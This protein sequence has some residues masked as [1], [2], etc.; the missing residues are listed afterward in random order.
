MAVSTVRASSGAVPYTVELSD[1]EGHRWIGDEPA[2]V[3]GANAGPSPE[4]LLLSALGSCTAATLLMY[5]RRKQWLLTQVHVELAFNPEGKPASGTD[6]S[7]SIQLVGQLDDEQRQ[8]LLQVAN[9]C[10]IHKV[11]T[12]EVRIATALATTAD[13]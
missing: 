8:R 13:A 12:G 7:R 5:A 6:I 10:P 3:G 4:H 11:L 9:A 1:N 2:D